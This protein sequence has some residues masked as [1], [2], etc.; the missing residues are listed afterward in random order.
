MCS[1]EATNQ[2]SCNTNAVFL[3][4][5]L[6]AESSSSHYSCLQVDVDMISTCQPMIAYSPKLESNGFSR[7]FRKSAA[8]DCPWIQLLMRLQWVGWLK[9][10]WF[11]QSGLP[12]PPDDV[13]W[14][15]QTQNASG[16]FSRRTHLFAYILQQL[17][18]CALCA[19]D[20]QIV[21]HN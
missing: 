4:K 8:W 14:C 19:R 9:I 2:N 5:I 21:K 6:I 20:K 16:S 17:C 18:L 13:T 3:T 12:T 7:I 1:Q 15:V 10:Q 11:G